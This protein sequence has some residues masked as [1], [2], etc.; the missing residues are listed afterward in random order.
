M[1]TTDVQHERRNAVNQYDFDRFVQA[2]GHPEIA[3]LQ[4]ADLHTDTVSNG[5]GDVVETLRQ[6]G[7][8]RLVAV[9]VDDEDAQLT[10]SLKS[11]G[12]RRKP[13]MEEYERPLHQP[14]PLVTD[15]P[16][17]IAVS[18]FH[19]LTADEV[20]PVVQAIFLDR[21]IV[22]HRSEFQEL[23]EDSDF[24]PGCSRVARDGD[25]IIGVQLVHRRAAT[26]VEL[27]YG[28]VT[29]EWRRRHVAL[30]LLSQSLGA[31]GAAGYR[32]ATGQVAVD[33]AAGHR[34]LGRAGFSYV[35][36]LSN[37]SLNLLRRADAPGAGPLPSTFQ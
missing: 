5:I 2:T 6:K 19:G 21:P 37:Y 30:A 33:N 23:L 7:F 1:K 22:A 12:F 28:G 3:I 4:H 17:Q 27:T 13:Q 9:S 35:R 29:P 11:V 36:S 32:T 34:F 18:D 24:L 14:P 20:Y 26:V 25:R 15:V 8:R 10:T 31:C 16:P